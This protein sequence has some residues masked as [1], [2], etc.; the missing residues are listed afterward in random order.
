MVHY[1]SDSV[2]NV[3]VK[4]PRENRFRDAGNGKGLEAVGFQL[5]LHLICKYW[6]VAGENFKTI[7]FIIINSNKIYKLNFN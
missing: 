5:I 3:G 4:F 6:R 1:G 2:V 7:T